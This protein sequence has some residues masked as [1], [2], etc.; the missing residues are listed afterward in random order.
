MKKVLLFFGSF[1]SEFKWYR[2]KKGG[3]WYNIRE[4]DVSGFAA[5]GSWWCQKLPD[6]DDYFILNNE[7]Y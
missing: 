2:K 7:S 3:S 5:P 6:G 4:Y 1:L